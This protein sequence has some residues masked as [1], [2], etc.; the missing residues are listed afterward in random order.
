MEPEAPISPESGEARLAA[1]VER[2]SASADLPA[3][4]HHVQELMSITTD[5]RSS[6][7]QVADTILKNV[8]LTGKVLRVVNAMH[9]NRLGEPILSISRAISLIGVNAIRD[10]AAGLL[11][12]EHFGDR[13]AG[14]RELVLLSL[15]SAN[16]ARQ[17][18]IRTGHVQAEEAYLC[19]MFRGLGEVLVA[20]YMPDEHAEILAQGAPHGRSDR[21]A[22]LR[23]LKFSYEDLGRAMA[24]QWRLG[25]KVSGAIRSPD[26]VQDSPGSEGE[27]LAL[28]TAFGHELSTCVYRMGPA[29]G[30]ERLL[31]LLRRWG[32]A[33]SLNEENIDAFL[34][35]ALAET[36]DTF[37]AAG[38]PLDRAQLERHIRRA[39]APSAVEEEPPVEASA[40]APAATAAKPALMERS[41]PA[42]LAA[43]TR[44]MKS[45]VDSGGARGLNDVILMT[46]EAMARGVGFDRVLFCLLDVDRSHI[47]AR[48][49]AGD[50]VTELIAR[51]RFP[52]SQTSEPV[53]TAVRLQRDVFVERVR[54]SRYG[55]TPFAAVV[56]AASFGL[57]PLELDGTVIGCFYF[58]R[59]TA[60]LGIDPATKAWLIGLRAYAARI[61]ANLRRR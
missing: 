12:F 4:S 8:S 30:R 3:F 49:G 57:L 5:E 16:H 17:A 40:P 25:D 41:G 7:W 56:G 27:R 45:V 15:L 59:R 23:V 48:M 14:V 21:E 39:V 20:C 58:D 22:A 34:T 54:E 2:L 19:G 24:Q 11:L 51:F 53:W 29:A 47:Q 6:L 42:T 10:L 61:A 26:T 44:E 55:R 38:V 37:A 52:I 32:P 60:D 46:I 18:A 28:V 35:A 31:A 43:L 50:G 36:R 13:G 1:C 33:M 9:Y